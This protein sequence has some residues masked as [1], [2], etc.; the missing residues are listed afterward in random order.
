MPVRGCDELVTLFSYSAL[1]GG[2]YKANSLWRIG[3]ACCANAA[4]GYRH[5]GSSLQ[6]SRLGVLPRLYGPPRSLPRAS[7]ALVGAI[8]PRSFGS[9]SASPTSPI[10]LIK[11]KSRPK[12][13]A[14]R[15]WRIG[16]SPSRLGVLPR[17]YGPPRSLPRASCALVGA[18]APRSLGSNPLFGWG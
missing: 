10:L 7:C 1:S 11:M 18:I 6:P 12:R 14:L 15:F 4:S 9:G 3:E 8:A 17:L 2:K 16:D 13:T 5:P